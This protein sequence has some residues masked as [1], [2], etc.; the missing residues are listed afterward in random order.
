[1]KKTTKR[2]LALSLFVLMLFSMCSMSAFAAKRFVPKQE[3][4]SVDYD[5]KCSISG[6]Q[7]VASNE[8]LVELANY[9]CNEDVESHYILY[10]CNKCGLIVYRIP[11]EGIDMLQ[12]HQNMVPCPDKPATCKE[13]GYKDAQ[14]CE[15]CGKVDAKETPKLTQHTD[16]DHNGVCDICDTAV[17]RYCTEVHTGFFGGITGFFHNILA[18]FGMHK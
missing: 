13:P 18:S 15:V 14:K 5:T 9:W 4:N 2:A 6:K 8:D 10:Y 3:D 17:C 11:S 7:H 12:D 1:M 16:T